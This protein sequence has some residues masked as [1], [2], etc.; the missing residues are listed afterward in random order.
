MSELLLRYDGWSWWS[1]VSVSLLAL[2]LTLLLAVRGARWRTGLF[3]AALVL[4]PL[5][6]SYQLVWSATLRSVFIASALQRRE[7]TTLAYVESWSDR[8]YWIC[9]LPIAWSSVAVVIWWLQRRS[10]FTR[11]SGVLMAAS[12]SLCGLA[13]A[14]LGVGIRDYF[15]ALSGVTTLDA[16]DFQRA[17]LDR[18]FWLAGLLFGGAGVSFGVLRSRAPLEPAPGSSAHWFAGLFGVGVCAVLTWLTAPLAAENATALPA[19]FNFTAG[20]LEPSGLRYNGSLR[21]EGPVVELRREIAGGDRVS[22]DFAPADRKLTARLRTKRE[23]WQQ[24]RSGQPFPGRVSLDVHVEPGAHEFS[25]AELDEWL[26][27]IQSAGYDHVDLWSVDSNQLQ[28]PLLGPLTAI[29]R[30]AIYTRIIRSQDDCA[31]EEQVQLRWRQPNSLRALVSQLSRIRERGAMPC[32]LV[33]GGACPQQSASCLSRLRGGY[34]LGVPQVLASRVSVFDLRR[35]DKRYH[36]VRLEE[37][38]AIELW[39]H[40]KD[41]RLLQTIDALSHELHSRGRRLL[42]AMNGGMYEPDH[43]PVGLAVS[44]GQQRHEL[45]T[46]DADGNFY[47]KPNGVFAVL[48]RDDELLPMVVDATLYEDRVQGWEVQHATQSGPLLLQGGRLH[49]RLDPDSTSRVRRNGVGVA[50]QTTFWVMSEDRVSFYELAE[51]FTLLGAP[52]ALYLD[53]NVSTLFA[54]EAGLI[55]GAGRLGPLLAVSE[56]LLPSP[57]TH[58]Q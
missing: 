1:L 41:G 22:V 6:L 48:A 57:E 36:V 31:A 29:S 24:V 56:P 33:S 47:L 13:L 9:G 54:P 38:A 7:M 52:D 2:P 21:R 55:H 16:G 3:W 53:G 28:R 42:L 27:A 45:N 44:F 49:P 40:G 43:S 46:E 50:G 14:V 12:L 19:G 25:T 32:L 23:L 17:A 10:S 51:V 30:T 11:T 26:H 58:Q 34:Q 15:A 37:P 8:A 20:L 35:R 5:L 4:S 18:S 39:T